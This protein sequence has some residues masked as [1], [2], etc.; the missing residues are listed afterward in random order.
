MRLSTGSFNCRHP[1]V[2]IVAAHGA[3]SGEWNALELPTPNGRK[4]YVTGRGAG[5]RPTTEAVM[6]DLF[7]LLRFQMTRS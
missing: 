3:L 6:A 5:R 7:D 1:A 2:L 4:E